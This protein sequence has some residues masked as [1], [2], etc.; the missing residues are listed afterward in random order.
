V[1]EKLKNRLEHDK[2]TDYSEEYRELVE[3][4]LD[5]G[6]GECILSDPAVAEL[7][8]ST[9]LNEHGKSCDIRAWVIMP[10][11]A[12]VMLRPYEG[13]DLA[14]IM[15]R[16]KGVSARKINQYLEREGTV[17]QA[18]YFDRFIRDEDDFLRKLQYIENNPVS[19]KLV[20]DAASWKFSSAGR[21]SEWRADTPVRMNAMHEDSLAG[22]TGDADKSVRAPLQDPVIGENTH[23]AH[24]H[25]KIRESHPEQAHPRE[26]HMAAIQLADPLPKAVLNRPRGKRIAAA[27]DQMPQRVA[28]ECV[29]AEQDD[30]HRQDQRSDADAKAVVELRRYG[31]V[32]CEDHDKDQSEI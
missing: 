28:S 7:V 16:M 2:F 30:I 27:T 20:S 13:H 22:G 32:I 23:R 3:Q 25:V 14:G 17:W 4:Y 6:A 18:D 11:H 31:G 29:P 12:H 1:I 15:K 5:D 9:I 24:P 26:Q 8:E 21:S 19:A 10:N